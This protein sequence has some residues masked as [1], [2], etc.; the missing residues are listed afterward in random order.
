[1]PELTSAQ[2]LALAEAVRLPVSADDLVEV[3]HRLNAFLEALAHLADLPLE[4][5]EPW[6]MLPDAS[7][8]EAGAAHGRT[9]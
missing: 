6:P 8:P 9:P 1:M 3:T 4:R 7:G 5:V 2:V